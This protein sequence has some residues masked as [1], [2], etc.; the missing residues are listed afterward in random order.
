MP[1]Y[2]QIQNGKV[3][4]ISEGPSEMVLLESN[5]NKLLG[6][7]Y[8]GL[9]QPFGDAT[10]F[11]GLK[12][13]LTADKTEFAADGVDVVT[14]S[15][16]IKNWKGEDVEEFAGMI[17]INVNGSRKDLTV[18]AGQ[19]TYVYKTTTIGKKN[20]STQDADGYPYILHGAVSVEAYGDLEE[21]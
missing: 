2:A 17:K 20:I 18:T 14:I 4:A 15:V 6:T 1:F 21:L 19:A 11:S 16:A 10:S 8:I 12:A 3:I 9:S 5:D 7:S 13:T